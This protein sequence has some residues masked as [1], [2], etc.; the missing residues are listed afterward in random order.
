[1]SSTVDVPKCVAVDSVEMSGVRERGEG[2]PVYLGDQNGRLC[3]FALTEGGHIA[4]AVDLLDL[5]VW[6]RT[7]RP[8]LITLMSRDE[9]V[10]VLEA[11]RVQLQV[12]VARLTEEVA[13]LMLLP[14]SS[15]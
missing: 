10:A 12:E 4:T 15:G 8:A 11:E 7:N 2:A 3:V 9:E 1:M 14:K 5:L 13:R 6:L